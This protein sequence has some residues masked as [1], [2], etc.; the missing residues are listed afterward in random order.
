M[1]VLD[2]C[3]LGSLC[4]TEIE[5][6]GSIRLSSGAQSRRTATGGEAA[7][8]T[9]QRELRRLMESCCKRRQQ[10]AKLKHHNFQS[11]LLLLLRDCFC[12]RIIEWWGIGGE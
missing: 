8:S 1:K 5:P 9:L 11:I 7:W 6:G 4:S 2:L 10:E 12:S 3:S